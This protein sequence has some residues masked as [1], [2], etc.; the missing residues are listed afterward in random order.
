MG[1]LKGWERV[2]YFL[3]MMIVVPV[4]WSQALWRKRHCVFG[5]KVVLVIVD[6]NQY[7]ECMNCGKTWNAD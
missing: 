3:L 5:H 4:S 1:R 7:N 6:D 2:L